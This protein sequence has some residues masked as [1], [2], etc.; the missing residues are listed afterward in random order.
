M[1]NYSLR[2]RTKNQSLLAMFDETKIMFHPCQRP[3]RTLQRKNLLPLNKR[4]SDVRQLTETSSHFFYRF[5]FDHD[6]ITLKIEGTQL[7]DEIL[8]NTRA[9]LRNAFEMDDIALSVSDTNNDK[10]YEEM[11]VHIDVVMGRTSFLYQSTTVNTSWYVCFK[12]SNG[13]WTYDGLDFA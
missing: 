12:A 6:N 11:L 8:N 4:D 1:T 3:D 7:T 9:V 2:Y 10:P 5:E 13:Q